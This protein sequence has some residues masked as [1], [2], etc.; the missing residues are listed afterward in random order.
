MTSGFNAHEPKSAGAVPLCPLL[1][2]PAAAIVSQDCTPVWQ[3]AV[4]KMVKTRIYASSMPMPVE[5]NN[6]QVYRR[7]GY[8]CWRCI[9]RCE[10]PLSQSGMIAL[11]WLYALPAL[12]RTT[13][14]A[15]SAW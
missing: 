13:F 5:I 15:D 2:T 4:S 3:L 6:G 11:H 1:E 14:E 9:R 8:H 7:H 10:S 12:P